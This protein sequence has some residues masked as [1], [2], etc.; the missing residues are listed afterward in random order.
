MKNVLSVSSFIDNISFNI[1]YSWI[2]IHRLGILFY[3]NSKLFCHSVV[4]A[5]ICSYFVL[6]C[7]SSSQYLANLLDS[8]FPYKI[9]ESKTLSIYRSVWKSRIKLNCFVLVSTW[10]S[11][12]I[13]CC[14]IEYWYYNYLTYIYFMKRSFFPLLLWPTTSSAI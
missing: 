3:F 14:C 10:A 1:G 13:H 2:Y 11:T 7:S 12:A 5:P 8:K 9:N 6:S 4:N